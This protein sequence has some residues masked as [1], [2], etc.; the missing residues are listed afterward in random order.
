MDKRA[1]RTEPAEAKL[2]SSE[3]RQRDNESTSINTSR[4]QAHAQS[5]DSYDES[6]RFRSHGILIPMCVEMEVYLAQPELNCMQQTLIRI[7]RTVARNRFTAE[8]WLV[9]SPIGLTDV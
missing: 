2:S 6:M 5:L 1:A 4:R 9:Y 7:S 3:G 8:S